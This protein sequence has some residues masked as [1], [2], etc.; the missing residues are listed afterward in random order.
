M[1]RQS[2]KGKKAVTELSNWFWDLFMNKPNGIVT[3]DDFSRRYTE[4]K[5]KKPMASE[6]YI[7]EL[8][9]KSKEDGLAF[10]QLVAFAKF[11]YTMKLMH[12]MVQPVRHF[13]EH[14]KDEQGNPSHLIYSVKHNNQRGWTFIN[15]KNEDFWNQTAFRNMDMKDAYTENEKRLFEQAWHELKEAKTE[16][17]REVAMRAIEI[18]T[19]RGRRYQYE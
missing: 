16:H 15:L 19:K 11:G 13:Y 2:K 14:E 1:G 6:E 10:D 7:S 3:M 12:K 17:A 9:K 18:F 8:K 4:T 5:Y